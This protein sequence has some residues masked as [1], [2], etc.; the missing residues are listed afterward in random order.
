MQKIQYFIVGATDSPSN[1][2]FQDTGQTRRPYKFLIVGS[3][4]Y[5]TLNR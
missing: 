3:A 4:P 5:P 2:M 1:P